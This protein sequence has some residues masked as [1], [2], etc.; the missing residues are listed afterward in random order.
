MVSDW[1]DEGRAP[2]AGGGHRRLRSW[3]GG[4]LA[5]RGEEVDGHDKKAD[6]DYWFIGLQATNTIGY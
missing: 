1:T 3:P 6:K 2:L 4:T 5:T